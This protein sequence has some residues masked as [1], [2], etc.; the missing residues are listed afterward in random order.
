[1]R[2]LQCVIEG[3]GGSGGSKQEV[4]KKDQKKR[5]RAKAGVKLVGWWLETREQSCESVLELSR[6]GKYVFCACTCV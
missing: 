3:L 4:E 2:P 6:R 1:M 5:K